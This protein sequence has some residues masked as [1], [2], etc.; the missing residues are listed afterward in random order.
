MLDGI[1]NYR[2]FSNNANSVILSVTRR[3]YI[4]PQNTLQTTPN[5]EVIAVE[6]GSVIFR[7]G[8]CTFIEASAGDVV[9]FNGMQP[10]CVFSIKESPC[11]LVTVSFIITAFMKEDCFVTDKGLT[12][13]FFAQIGVANNLI[14]SDAK[15][16]SDIRNTIA[17]IE[18]EMG[19]EGVATESVVRAL[20]ILLFTKL[21]RHYTRQFKKLNLKKV[22]HYTDIQ[23]AMVYINEHLNEEIALEDLARI[24]NMNKTYFSTVFKKVTG[25]TVWD[26][27]LAARVELAIGYLTKD[28]ADYNITEICGLCGFNNAASFNKTFKRF[29]GKTP[30]EFKKTKYNSCFSE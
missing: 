3:E 20:T 28:K 21:L 7:V 17:D 29:T 1:N 4:A 13:E 15:Y 26:Y 25:K 16:C 8:D 19:G 22:P 23:N 30:S 10:H 9:F 12:D 18:R 27:I 5:M 11:S 6:S 14:G 24:A 2:L